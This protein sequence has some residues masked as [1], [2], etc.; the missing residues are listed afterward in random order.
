M[1]SGARTVRS[2]PPF[3]AYSALHQRR[4]GIRVEEYRATMQQFHEVL[5]DQSARLL[6]LRAAE[7]AARVDALTLALS[8]AGL[9]G[10]PLEKARTF[11]EEHVSGDGPAS[12]RVVPGLIRSL[13]CEAVPFHHAGTTT[14]R[15]SLNGDNYLRSLGL[16]S[17]D[18]GGFESSFIVNGGQNLEFLEHLVRDVLG[19]YG[20]THGK[21][22]GEFGNYGYAVYNLIYPDRPGPASLLSRTVDEASLYFSKPGPDEIRY[23]PFRKGLTDLL[24]A[25]NS[26]FPDVHPELWQR[27]LGLGVG[28][29]FVLRMYAHDRGEIGEIVSWLDLRGIDSV[30]QT[31]LLLQGRMVVRKILFV[32]SAA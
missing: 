9:S 26:A 17:G 21:H 10:H 25:V 1:T 28:V 22:L 3:I 15:L 27:K 31:A 24:K 18:N 7:E 30:L 23:A 29:E 19:I 32:R 6:A 12:D 14:E 8:S 2:R 5:H 4:P 11:M 13:E 16:H 20:G